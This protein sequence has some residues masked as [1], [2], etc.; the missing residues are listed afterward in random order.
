MKNPEKIV[1]VYGS[2]MFFAAIIYVTVAYLGLS[3]YGEMTQSN[4]LVNVT[5]SKSGD[6][7]GNI[8]QY[9]YLVIPLLTVP[10]LYIT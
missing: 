1:V 10:I 8:I 3:L 9:M 5:R 2:S 7:L 6:T 4:V